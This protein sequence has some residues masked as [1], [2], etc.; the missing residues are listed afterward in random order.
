MQVYMNNCDYLINKPIRAR[1]TTLRG[2]VCQWLATGWCFFPCPTVSSTNKTDRHDITEILLKVALNTVK[3][4][5][6]GTLLLKLLWLINWIIKLEINAMQKNIIIVSCLLCARHSYSSWLYCTC[7]DPTWYWEIYNMMLRDL[8]HDTERFTTWY[9]EI[10]NM[11][12]RDLQ[13]DTERFT[14][15]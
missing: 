3:Q 5:S 10:Y 2:K 7:T 4:T 14:T 1:C 15:W 13:H 9:W 8:Q 12:L 6:Y 11:I